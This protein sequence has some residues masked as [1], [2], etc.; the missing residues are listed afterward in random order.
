M[1][2]VLL[3]FEVDLT[4]DFSKFLCFIC[5]D[6]DLLMMQNRKIPIRMTAKTTMTRYI[7]QR[8]AGAS[9]QLMKTGLVIFPALFSHETWKEA[10]SKTLE[11]EPEIVPVAASIE[12]PAGSCGATVHS[13]SAP[14][15]IGVT[16][17]CCFFVN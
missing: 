13:Y 17:P 12:R 14:S 2:V 6:L 8:E 5:L 7:H 16:D 9:T 3:P 4:L 11:Q 15:M 1:L 10:R